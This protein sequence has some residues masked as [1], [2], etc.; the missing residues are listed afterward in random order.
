MYDSR[1]ELI[2]ELQTNLNPMDV[3][4]ICLFN[5]ELGQVSEK[6]SLLH[7]VKDNIESYHESC[8][9]TDKNTV[10]IT[11]NFNTSDEMTSFSKKFDNAKT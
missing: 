1:Y 5:T 3:L 11:L 4:N 10:V 9:E 8:E 6:L 2:I 7:Q